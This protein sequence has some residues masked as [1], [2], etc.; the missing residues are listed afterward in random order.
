V[1]RIR[2]EAE[3][4]AKQLDAVS[5][6]DMTCPCKEKLSFS[7]VDVFCEMK[8]PNCTIRNGQKFKGEVCGDPLTDSWT[9][10]PTYYA[11]GC[12]AP[13]SSNGNKPF[14]ND[15]VAA[16]SPEEKRRADIYKASQSS[17]GAGG[18]M[19]VYNDGPKPS[20]TIRSFRLSMCSPPKEQVV[21]VAVTRTGACE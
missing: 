5:T 17:G 19:C 15:C 14:S 2:S 10:T 12:G 9:I 1:D 13:P 18:W 8:M 3:L 20:V 4:K 6:A 11:T 16:G 21:T 7:G